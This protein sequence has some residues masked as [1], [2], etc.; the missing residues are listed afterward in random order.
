MNEPP[1]P[2]LRDDQMIHEGYRQDPGA[3][4]AWVFFLATLVALLWGAGSWYAGY[5]Q[6]QQAIKPFLRVSNRAMSVFLWQHPEFLRANAKAKS[7]YLPAFQYLERVSVEPALADQTVIAPPEL[8]FQ[9][10]TW[11]RLVGEEWFPRAIPAAQFVAFLDYCEEW[12]PRYW[13]NAPQAYQEMVDTLNSKEDLDLQQLPESTL[14][15]VVR[16]A[17]Q[18]WKNFRMEGDAINRFTPTYA[19]VHEFLAKYPYYARNYWQNLYDDQTHQY[20]KTVADHPANEEL[21]P[22]SDLVPFLRTALFN[23]KSS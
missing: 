13:P 4:W 1:K 17:F 11:S 14:P 10:H 3:L 19:Q 21:L 16:I 18:G 20:L 23:A 5:I 15:R 6:E 8:L 2:P 9:F 22:A 7:G 12:Q